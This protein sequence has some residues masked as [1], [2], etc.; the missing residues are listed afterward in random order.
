MHANTVATRYVYL[1]C[2]QYQGILQSHHRG[3]LRIST[4]EKKLLFVFC[5]YSVAGVVALVSFG[6]HT[7]ASNAQQY[8]KVLF[9]Y[10]DCEATGVNPMDSNHCNKEF[11]NILYYS[12]PILFTITILLVT[13]APVVYLIFLFNWKLFKEKMLCCLRLLFINS[14]VRSE[15]HSNVT[16]HHH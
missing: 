15:S 9:E 8:K 14:F 1:H 10:F 3:H 11:F 12:Y 7:N 2:F 5:Y 16:G 4:A 6:L 13:F